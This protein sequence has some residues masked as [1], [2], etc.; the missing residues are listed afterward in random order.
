MH[1]S[2]NDKGRAAVVLDTGAASRGSGNAGTNKEKTVRQWFVNESK[3][4]EDISF[5]RN[6]DN[7]RCSKMA[8]YCPFYRIKQ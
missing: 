7:C 2:L 6:R 5:Q 4:G 3:Y 8:D 1:A